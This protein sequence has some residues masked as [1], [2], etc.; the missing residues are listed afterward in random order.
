MQVNKKNLSDTKVQLTVEADAKLLA[1]AK[2]ET[3]E[4]LA[5]DMKLPGF[6]PGKAPAA[7]VEKNA[8]PTTLQTEFLD[9]AMNAVYAAALDQ[10]KLRPVASPKVEVKKFVPFTTLELVFEVEV[11]GEVT[12]P[13]YKKM[14]K[15]APEIKITPKDV[16][17]VIEQLKKRE[18]VRQDVDRPAK[19]GDEVWIDFVGTDAKTKEPIKGADGKDYPLPLG[20]NTFIP[21]FEEEVVGL[22]PGAEKSFVITF[23]AD[24]GV[25][26]LQKRKVEFKVTVKKIQELAE[27]KLDDALAAKVGPFKTVAEL[28]ADIKKQLEIEKTKQAKREFTDEL[29]LDI[30]KKS[31]VSLPASLLDEQVDR[32]VNEQKQN[33]MYRGQTWKEFLEEQK[34]TEEAYRKKQLPD[35][36]LRVKAG[37]VLGEV[38]EKEKIVVTAEELE[39][40]IQLLKGQY[41]DAQMQAELNKPESRRE[42]ASRLVSEK[43]IDK[44]TDY[45]LDNTKPIKKR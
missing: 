34:L 17:G 45:V 20:S 16:D 18:A 43:T 21:G 44:L 37:I 5:A 12:L 36:E 24:Y 22:K 4:H 19:A 9:R 1:A 10:E 30:T 28:K 42:I 41:T 33:L 39:I 32:L 6:R 2:K 11:I 40:R 26:S 35:A 7:I 27:P 8:N 25:P 23:P 38:A 3:L 29:L 14:K 15:A 31:K 13:D